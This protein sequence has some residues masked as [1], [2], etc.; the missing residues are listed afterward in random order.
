MLLKSWEA[1]KSSLYGATFNTTDNAKFIFNISSL[2]Y[3]HP[4]T[5]ESSREIYKRQD[6]GRIK[7]KK[8]ANLMY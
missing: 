4:K 5:L 2:K 6:E 7:S 3:K 1:E 8:M